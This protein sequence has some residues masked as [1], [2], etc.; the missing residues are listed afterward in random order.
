MQRA[1]P[2]PV[3]YLFGSVFAWL[4]LLLLQQPLTL[5]CAFLTLLVRQAVLLSSEDVADL[6]QSLPPS[7]LAAYLLQLSA[8]SELAAYLIHLPAPSELAACWKQ[9]PVLLEAAALLDEAI[10]GALL[11]PRRDGSRLCR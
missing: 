10:G 3:Y 9:L 6:H 2:S 4:G 8:L 5:H 7:E 11:W 1:V